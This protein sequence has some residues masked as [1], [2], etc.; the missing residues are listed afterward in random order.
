M[1]FYFSIIFF[2]NCI[3][4]LI[5]FICIR[6]WKIDYISDVPLTSSID[7]A[8][9]LAISYEI[10]H[11]MCKILQ[12]KFD[13]DTNGLMMVEALSHMMFDVVAINLFIPYYVIVF[14]VMG[15]FGQFKL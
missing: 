14:D 3:L 1:N 12:D 2:A 15:K 7:F 13:Y 11:K 5:V 4:S 8:L 10:S 9:G 6:V